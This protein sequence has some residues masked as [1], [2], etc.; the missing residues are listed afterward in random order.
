MGAAAGLFQTCRY[1][2]SVLST[3]LLGVVFAGGVTSSGLHSLG[4]ALAFLSLLLLV[5]MF[6]WS[7]PPCSSS[8][9]PR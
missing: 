4:A 8:V 7:G 5:G 1:V 3:S 9:S 6:R 2:G